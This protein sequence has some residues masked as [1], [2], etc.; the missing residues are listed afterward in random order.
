MT[1]FVGS[2]H[3]CTGRWSLRADAAI[4]SPSYTGRLSIMAAALLGM[5]AL[6]WVKEITASRYGWSICGANLLALFCAYPKTRGFE[7]PA[8]VYRPIHGKAA[9]KTAWSSD[10]TRHQPPAVGNKAETSAVTSLRR[11]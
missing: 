11:M 9:L 10:E 5:C 7:V 8:E 1:T 4:V 3:T 6:R 2:I